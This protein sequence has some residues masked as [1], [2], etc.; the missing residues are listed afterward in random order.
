LATKG[1]KGTWNF[2]FVF[3]TKAR[4]IRKVLAKYI[5]KCLLTHAHENLLLL[6]HMWHSGAFATSKLTSQGT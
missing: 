4:E 6:R 2:F 5:E 3:G 1:R